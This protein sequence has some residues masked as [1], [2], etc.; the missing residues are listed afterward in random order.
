LFPQRVKCLF[1]FLP[2]RQPSDDW[3]HRPYRAC[4]R[5]RLLFAAA[6]HRTGGQTIVYEG[7]GHCDSA[8][9]RSPSMARQSTGLR[10]VF[11]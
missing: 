2:F 10:R 4:L 8:A 11:I 6:L 3:Q 5:N 1:A 9:W 7:T